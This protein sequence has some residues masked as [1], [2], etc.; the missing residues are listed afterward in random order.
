MPTGVNPSLDKCTAYAG[1]GAMRSGN[2]NNL[3]R[4]ETFLISDHHT[5]I[6]SLKKMTF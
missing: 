5:M 2:R 6:S 3:C 1:V 4:A